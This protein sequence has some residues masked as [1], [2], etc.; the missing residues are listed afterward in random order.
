MGYIPPVSAKIR[1]SGVLRVPLNEKV[2]AV[3]RT[4]LKKVTVRSHP[5]LLREKFP[6]YFGQYIDRKV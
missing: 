3:N 1:K 6:K 2:D 5:K 4:N